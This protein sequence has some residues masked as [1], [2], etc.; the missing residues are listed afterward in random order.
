[1]EHEQSAVP[2]VLPDQLLM[3]SLGEGAGGIPAMLTPRVN[4][5][6]MPKGKTKLPK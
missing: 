1:M 5:L 2:N 4:L 6:T 3:L